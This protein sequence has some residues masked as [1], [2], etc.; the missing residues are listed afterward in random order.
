MTPANAPSTRLHVAAQKAGGPLTAKPLVVGVG[1]SAG[2]LD[3][4]TKMLGALPADSGLAIVVVQHLDPG[5]RS[6]LTEL[7]AR[8]TKMDVQEAADGQRVAAGHVYIMPPNTA[9]TINGGR[10]RIRPRSNSKR[11]HL[12]VDEFFSSLAADQGSAAAGVILSGTAS[13]GA[14]GTQAIKAAGGTTFAQEE[15]TASYPGMPHAAIASGAVDHVLAPEAI[16]RKLLDLVTHGK[17]HPAK[18][19]KPKPGANPPED[20][21]TTILEL[22]ASTGVD[23]RHYKTNSIQRRIQRRMTLTGERSLES[24]L[25]RLRADPAE[26]RALHEGLLV[27]VTEFFRNPKAFLA[28]KA[29]AF[30]KILE[31]KPKGQSVRIWVAGCSTGEEAYSIAMAYLESSDAHKP[32]PPLQL[33]ATDLSEAA[34]AKAR[35][36]TYPKKLLA[37]VSPERLRRFFV[38]AEDGKSYRITKEVRQ[39]CVFSRHDVT[40]DPPFAKLDLISCRNLLI[41]LGNDLQDRVIPTFHYA[42]NPNGFLLLGSSESLPRFAGAFEAVDPGNRLFVKGAVAPPKTRAGRPRP[43]PLEVQAPAPSLAPALDAK[44]VLEQALLATSAQAALL[45]NEQLDILMLHGELDPY[46]EVH[47]GSPGF[48]VMRLARQGLGVEVGRAVARA[49]RQGKGVHVADI[50]IQRDGKLRELDLHVT[51]LEAP[52]RGS[53]CYLVAFRAHPVKRASRDARGAKRP[54]A[55]KEILRL[56]RELDSTKKMMQSIIDQAES[57]NERLQAASEELQSANEELQSTNEELQTSQEELQSTNEELTTL[58]EEMGSSNAE[59]L[60]LGDDLENV[61]SS[62]KVSIILLD[63]ELRIRRMTPTVRDILNILPA[64]IGRPLTDIALHIGGP[65]LHSTIAH[66]LENR[67]LAALETTDR[68][69]RWY[70]IAVRPYWKQRKTLDGVVLTFTDIDDRKKSLELAQQAQAALE[71]TSRRL[72]VSNAQLD[73]VASIASHDLREPLRMVASYLQLLD[74]RSGATLDPEAATYLKKALD[75]AARMQRLISDLLAYA[76]LNQA[77]LAQPSVPLEEVLAEAVQ[78]LRVVFKKNGAKVTHD[79]LPTVAGIPSQL[80][81]LFQNLIANGVKFH[82]KQPPRIHV[83][84]VRAGADWQFAVRDNGIG[85]AAKDQPRLFRL[86]QR[87][88]TRAEYDGTGLGLA[89]AKKIVENHGGRIWVESAPGKGSTFFFTLHA[90]AP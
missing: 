60:S 10:L 58:N 90:E 37:N 78:N 35:S 82:G 19:A 72:A 49:R 36:G 7:L 64:D 30:P 83:G 28:L 62:A 67:E 73:E 26:L 80:T 45:V 44:R 50:H 74:E 24:Y 41:Y 66:V 4:V 55:P 77:V 17:R 13:D 34:I 47:A 18:Q 12:P 76:K 57:A 25:E 43:L 6:A 48:N 15:A 16:G 21:V 39:L 69:G 71:V 22:L 32:R 84:A 1:A 70:E 23:F 3:A 52:V 61:F 8:T 88:H 11:P 89:I 31:A 29:K 79:P 9:L 53:P 40:H 38:E 68:K 87:L 2:G 14:E 81:E 75:G 42:L 5:H 46:L 54:D 85:I 33:F 20:Q 63:G 56:R 86:F 51:P 65:T 59:L 27:P